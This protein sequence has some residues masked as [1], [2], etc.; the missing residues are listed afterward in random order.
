[1]GKRRIV[2]VSFTQEEAQAL[3][4]QV[5]TM[6][7]SAENYNEVMGAITKLRAALEG[8]AGDTLTVP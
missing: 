1:M 4:R 5:W 6:S 8:G 7:T 2:K 3:L